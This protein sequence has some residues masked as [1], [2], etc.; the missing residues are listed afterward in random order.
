MSIVGPNGEKMLMISRGTGGGRDGERGT[1]ERRRGRAQGG[2]R[3]GTEHDEHVQGPARSIKSG[4]RTR[5]SPGAGQHARA[6]SRSEV[7]QGAAER[8][9]ASRGY[10]K[11][12]A[13]IHRSPRRR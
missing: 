2:A 11:V 8:G 9:F 10:Q 3:L 13:S 4:P 7:I 12:Y 5:R 1:V 6:A